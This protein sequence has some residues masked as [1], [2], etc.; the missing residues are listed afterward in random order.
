M[1]LCRGEYDYEFMDYIVKILRKCKEYGFRVFVDP[2]QDVVCRV[3][4]PEVAVD[5]SLVVPVYRWLWCTALDD[6]CMWT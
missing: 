6:L 4:S 5:V 3:F 2:H 1:H